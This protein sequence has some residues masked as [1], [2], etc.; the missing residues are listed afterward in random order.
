MTARIWLL[1]GLGALVGAAAGAPAPA[2]GT[3]RVVSADVRNGFLPADQQLIK[4]QQGD[5]VTPRWTTDAPLTVHLH[6][7]DIEQA[8]APGAPVEMRFTARATG[9]FPVERH[10]S[11]GRPDSTLCYLEVYPR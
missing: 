2:A 11:A 3:S 10:G 1:V 6:G 8:L 7:Y 4:A 9:R 5:E